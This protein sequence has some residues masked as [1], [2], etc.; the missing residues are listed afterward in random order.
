[1][2]D[3]EDI[4]SFLYDQLFLLEALQRFV[5][6]AGGGY[7]SSI[8]DL[9]EREGAAARGSASATAAAEGNESDKSMESCPRPTGEGGEENR[10]GLRRQPRRPE[11][12]APSSTTTTF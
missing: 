10:P 5:D 3:F 12:R 2:K 1:M 11:R 4:A 8:R 9:L 6:S 7:F